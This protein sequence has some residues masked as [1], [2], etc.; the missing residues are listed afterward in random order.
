MFTVYYLY[1][2]TFTSKP[3]LADVLKIFENFQG[4]IYIYA[5]N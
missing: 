2:Q 1:K 3:L 5:F 4:D